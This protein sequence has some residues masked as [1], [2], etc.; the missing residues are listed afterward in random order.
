MIADEDD[1]SLIFTST[2]EEE[3][4]REAQ[5]TRKSTKENVVDDKEKLPPRSKLRS[6]IVVDSINFSS[7]QNRLENFEEDK[8][9]H[10]HPH[11]D[12]EKEVE[13][14]SSGRHKSKHRKHKHKSHK[15]HKHKDSSRERHHDKQM[16]DAGDATEVNKE[17]EVISS[18]N[19]TSNGKTEDIKHDE[20]PI[21]QTLEKDKQLITIDKMKHISDPKDL[22][23]LE[24]LIRERAILMSK[25]I[26]TGLD[27]TTKDVE[28]IEDILSIAEL[29]QKKRELL[30]KKKS[31]ETKQATGKLYKTVII[32]CYLIIN[33]FRQREREKRRKMANIG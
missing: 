13:K 22:D 5:K 15:K 19:A 21:E 2:S 4:E 24:L 30:E 28:P 7:A 26:S 3:A 17:K 31:E 33:I 14:L 23:D 25:L 6:A 1:S 27:K 16:S 9:A 32:L 10:K 18:R 20:R 8:K 12:S 29:K 11:S